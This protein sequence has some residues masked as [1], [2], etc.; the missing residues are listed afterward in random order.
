MNPTNDNRGDQ[1]NVN[2]TDTLIRRGRRLY[3][4]RGAP[5]LPADAGGRGRCDGLRTLAAAEGVADSRSAPTGHRRCA[6][7]RTVRVL[8]GDTARAPT[9]CA[10]A[11]AGRRSKPHATPLDT[12]LRAALRARGLTLGPAGSRSL[13]KEEP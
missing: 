10:A 13:T 3:V 2:P 12:Y 4:A 11:T 9:S 7:D 6:G 5:A 1:P 8:A